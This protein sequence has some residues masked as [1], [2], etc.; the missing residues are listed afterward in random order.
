M[1]S[2]K[3]NIPDDYFL[4]AIAIGRAAI[5]QHIQN[6][7]PERAK[8]PEVYFVDAITT[9]RA[10]ILQQVMDSRPEVAVMKVL[11]QMCPTAN[12]KQFFR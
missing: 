6:S 11:S 2:F 10:A 12:N 5:I 9:S 3:T 4:D 7:K 1:R 8:I